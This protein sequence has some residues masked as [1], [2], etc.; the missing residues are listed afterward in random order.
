[1]DRASRDPEHVY[2]RRDALSHFIDCTH[3][4]SD[5]RKAGE[6]ALSPKV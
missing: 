2:L 4:R 3:R 5:L 6:E 1:M